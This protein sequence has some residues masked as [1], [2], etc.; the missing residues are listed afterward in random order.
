[1]N[2]IFKYEPHHKNPAFYIHVC[3]KKDADLHFC[4]GLKDGTIPLLLESETSSFYV[5]VKDKVD[6]FYSLT[7]SFLANSE[8]YLEKFVSFSFG[9]TTL[10]IVMGHL[11]CL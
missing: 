1:M 3:E 7:V 11:I 10:T 2:Q 4:F 6:S 9:V 8:I 5:T